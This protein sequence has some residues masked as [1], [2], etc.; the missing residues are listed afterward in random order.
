ME[1]RKIII[2][3]VTVAFLL[4]LLAGWFVLTKTTVTRLA[5]SVVAGTEQYGGATYYATLDQD[6]TLSV[7]KAISG[8]IGVLFQVDQIHD[9]TEIVWSPDH[10]AAAFFV[11]P[12]DGEPA[13][14]LFQASVLVITQNGKVTYRG[15]LPY[16]DVAFIDNDSLVGYIADSESDTEED[17][18]EPNV[19]NFVT[20]GMDGKANKLL[21][22]SS[23]ELS[24]ATYKDGQVAFFGSSPDEGW[25]SSGLY[26][27]DI[28]KKTVSQIF[29]ID[30]FAGAELSQS[31]GTMLYAHL[32]D[33]AGYEVVYSNV[34]GSNAKVVAAN[35]Y[36]FRLTTSNGSV[37]GFEPVSGT[38]DPENDIYP[39]D[40]F[41]NF[42]RNKVLSP[43]TKGDGALSDCSSP[44]ILSNKEATFVCSGSLYRMTAW[45]L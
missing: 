32:T 22:Y 17:A 40:K 6:G 9:V 27:L 7:N 12:G 19:G 18:I 1:K 44:Q 23:T 39:I 38:Y 24:I 15:E 25:T 4:L 21:E 26:S 5:S 31:L 16:S 37:Y 42:T 43:T 41:V 30:G 45:S 34:D 20:L 33:N 28:K 29:K 36:P 10:T 35:N 2:I 3:G 13:V 8:K 11:I 14:N